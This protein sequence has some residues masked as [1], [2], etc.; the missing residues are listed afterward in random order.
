MTGYG[1]AEEAVGDTTVQVEVRSVNGR[2]L[3]TKV[4]APSDLMRIEGRVEAEVKKRL[5]RGQVDV[6]VRVSRERVVEPRIDRDT[7]SR[8]VDVLD[9][10]GGEKSAALLALPGVVELADRT[11]VTSSLERHVVRVARLALDALVEAR[12]DEGTRLAKVLRRELARLAKL[13]GQVARRAP[14]TVRR[15]HAQLRERLEALLDGTPVDA[16]DATIAR[17]VAVL[18]DRTDVTE[19][20]DRLESHLE[21]LERML[22]GDGSV[23]RELDFQLQE[24]G[25]EINT[26]GSKGN[27]AAIARTV[28]AMKSAVEK[29]REQAANIE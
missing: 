27:D 20:L 4:R 9:G 23:G 3:A 24:V 28:V 8:Y 11:A 19:E 17:E 29:L 6:I 26:I 21:A 14:A 16:A 5:A 25:R 2:Y 18:A 12:E 1:R 13:R 15:H 22:E 10:L 7:L